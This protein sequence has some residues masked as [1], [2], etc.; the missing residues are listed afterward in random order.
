MFDVYLHDAFGIITGL[1]LGIILFMSLYDS[2]RDRFRGWGTA[3]DQL[4]E[5]PKCRLTFLVHRYETV[6]RCPRCNTL[7][8]SLRTGNSSHRRGP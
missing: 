8:Q 3:E 2:W 4:G 5:C 6:V 1:L 7:C